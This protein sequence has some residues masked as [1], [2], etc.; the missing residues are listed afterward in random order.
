MPA[1][2]DV[3][4]RHSLDSDVDLQGYESDAVLD[5]VPHEATI[6]GLVSNCS[7]QQYNVDGI[8]RKEW[9]VSNGNYIRRCNGQALISSRSER[10]EHLKDKHMNIQRRKA[11]IPVE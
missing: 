10:S 5:M 9:S 2:L 7:V 4:D 1:L 6:D 8:T 11:T 3:N